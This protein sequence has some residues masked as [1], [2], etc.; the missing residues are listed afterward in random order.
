M[1]LFRAWVIHWAIITGVNQPIPIE[2]ANLH[3][4]YWAQVIIDQ[5]GMPKIQLDARTDSRQYRGLALHEVCHI[6]LRHGNGLTEKQQE[7]EVKQCMKS[8]RARAK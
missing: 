1:N 7:K 5:Y 3:G 4:K 2:L 6:K 8:Y